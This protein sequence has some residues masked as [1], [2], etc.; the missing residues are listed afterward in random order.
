MSMKKQKFR[1]SRVLPSFTVDASTHAAFMHLMD[2]TGDLLAN[3]MNQMLVLG[4]KKYG[5]CPSKF[6][7]DPRSPTDVEKQR[8]KRELIRFYSQPKGRIPGVFVNRDLQELVRLHQGKQET[9]EVIEAALKLWLKAQGPYVA[10]EPKERP[11]RRKMQRAMLLSENP[12]DLAREKAALIAGI[13]L[14]SLK[15][16]D[17]FA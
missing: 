5:L 15:K 9:R 14:S 11:P 1:N 2:S 12:P 6:R 16:W 17:D 13:P 3:L 4:L 10:P 8:S 7:P